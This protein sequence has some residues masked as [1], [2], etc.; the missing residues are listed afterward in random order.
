MSKSSAAQCFRQ[1]LAAETPLQIVGT[2]NPYCAIMAKS[3]GFKAIYLSGGACANMSYGLPD[4][5]LTTLENVLADVERIVSACD[6]PLLVDIDTGFGDAVDIERTIRS[7]IKAGVAA[8]H[9]EDQVEKKR[10]GHRPGKTLVSTEEMVARVM[11][12][13]SAKTESDFYIIARTDAVASEGLAAA[14]ARA[15]AYV[16][17]GVDAIFAEAVTTLEDYRQFCHELSVPVLANITEFGK[18]P[19]FTVDELRQVGIKMVL[20]PFTAVRAMNQAAWSV[21]TTLRQTGTQKDLIAT[22]QD[23][24]TLY[25]FL[26]YYNQEK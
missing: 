22:M 18:T 2:I 12:A 6:L 24:E 19:L 23:R 14:I 16:A 8:V 17:A 3:A 21:Y 11:A 13:V 4:L 26:D 7:M 10:C 25:K 5:G 1:A 15:Q 20:Y 9:M